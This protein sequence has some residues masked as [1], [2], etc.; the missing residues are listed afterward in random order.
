MSMPLELGLHSVEALP[1]KSI[2]VVM[3]F[4]F[5]SCDFVDRCFWPEKDDP[6]SHTN[7]HELKFFRFELDVTFEAKHR[8]EIRCI[9][10][11]IKSRRIPERLGFAKE[12][13][14]CWNAKAIPQGAAALWY[15]LNS[16]LRL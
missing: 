16:Q 15:R 9:S 8:V 4:V 6:R 2:L 11:N 7:Q 1:Q 14:T 10:E 5:N 13:R 12:S 3:S